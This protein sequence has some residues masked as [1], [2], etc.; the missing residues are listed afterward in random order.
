MNDRPPN[1]TSRPLRLIWVLAAGVLRILIVGGLVGAGVWAAYWFNATEGASR[2]VDETRAEASR[3]VQIEVARRERATVLVRAMGTVTATREVVIRPRVGGEIVEQHE[4]FVPGGFFDRGSF[5]VRID[6]SDYQQTVKERESALAQAEAALKI[7]LGDQAVAEEELELLDIEI[8][9]INRDLILRIPQVNRARAEIRAAEAALARAELDL[10]RTRI[11]APFDGHLVERFVSEGDNVG[12]GDQLAVFVGAQEYW[13]DLSVPIASLRWIRT[14]GQ[15]GAGSP[16]IV[17]Q[18]GAW[19]DGVSREG[20]VAQR[21]GRLEEGSR[22]ARVLVRIPDPLARD[23]AREG[24]PEMIL[25]AF[26][27]VEIRG[28]AIDDAFVIDR[29]HL[30]EGDTVW[31]MGDDDRLEIK[32]VGVEHRG[33]DEVYITSGLEDGDRVVRTNL[34]TPV[35]GMLL[36]VADGDAPGREGGDDDG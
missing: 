32:E 10:E 6:P 15:G 26:V 22:L 5:L 3:L 4:N 35:E 28:R 36:R 17:R 9:E 16:A 20:V 13:V 21:I 23:P 2:R 33:R 18:P 8:P 7:E 24:K 27:D 34:T 12:A 11:A 29:D 31:V 30:R 25:G 1:K 14:P 19:G